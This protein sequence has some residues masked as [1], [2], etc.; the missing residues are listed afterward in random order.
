[1]NMYTYIHMYIM[2][3]EGRD[4]LCLLYQALHI[5]VCMYICMWV[6][7]FLQ[8]YTHVCPDVFWLVFKFA[9]FV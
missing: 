8:V 2:E 1:M 4:E 5:G 3:R 6:C 7:I 9:R